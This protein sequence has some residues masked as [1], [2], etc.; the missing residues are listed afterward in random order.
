MDKEYLYS[1]TN[2]EPG[3]GIRNL[4]KGVCMAL[5]LVLC[6]ISGRSWAAQSIDTL[7]QVQEELAG[8]LKL[9]QDALQKR[10]AAQLP[11]G[12]LKDS[13]TAVVQLLTNLMQQTTALQDLIAAGPTPNEASLIVAE[14]KKIK[15]KMPDAGLTAQEQGATAASKPTPPVNS[16]T[17][18]LTAPNAVTPTRGQGA[19]AVKASPSAA[20]TAQPKATSSAA[21]LSHMSFSYVLGVSPKFQSNGQGFQGGCTIGSNAITSDAA[22][23]DVVITLVAQQ[24]QGLRNIE[25][26]A[27][28][29]EKTLIVPLITIDQNTEFLVS[30]RRTYIGRSEQNIL[31]PKFHF[32]NLSLNE[33]TDLLQS[34]KANNAKIQ[35]AF[36][37]ATPTMSVYQIIL[38]AGADPDSVLFF[39]EGKLLNTT[40]ISH[41]NLVKQLKAD[42]GKDL[43]IGTE[44]KPQM[45]HIPAALTVAYS[46]PQLSGDS[47]DVVANFAT[48]LANLGGE[49][50]HRSH[51]IE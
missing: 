41:D 29:D 27:L 26:L 3:G 45:I 14:W 49:S 19:A 39:L 12:P 51:E 11:P 5:L 21:D 31:N 22:I 48:R 6:W 7:D 32:R 20:P 15:A 1:R 35:A 13:N 10:Q 25:D 42:E 40:G 4:A 38:P 30:G 24:M 16:G 37:T 44:D 28:T 43:N 34:L 17:V 47:G 50:R 9:M 8:N 33:V 36:G 2:L 46:A 23:W 18:G